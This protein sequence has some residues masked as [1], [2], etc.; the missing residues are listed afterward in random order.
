MSNLQIEEKY[1]IVIINYFAARNIIDNFLPSSRLHLDRT[2]GKTILVI[3]A[4]KGK[5]S[6]L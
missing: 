1:K 6:K 2:S 3:G 4:K 5:H